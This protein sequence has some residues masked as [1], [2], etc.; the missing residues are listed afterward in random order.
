MLVQVLSIVIQ[1]VSQAAIK[2]TQ[3]LQIKQNSNQEASAEADLAAA[4]ALLQALI[5]PE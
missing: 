5:A 3:S 1:H 2:A 4:A